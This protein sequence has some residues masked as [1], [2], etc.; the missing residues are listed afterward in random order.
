MDIQEIR[1]EIDGINKDLI[2]LMEKRLQLVEKIAI[3]KKEKGLSI[4]DPKREEAIM[5]DIEHSLT[6]TVYEP[7]IREFMEDIIHISRTLQR[8]RLKQFIYLVGMPGSGKTTVG[9]ALAAQLDI[10]F[11]DVDERIQKKA[12]QSLQHIMIKEGEPAFR[13]LENEVIKEIVTE[14]PGV[15]ATGGGTVLS[16]KTVQLMRETGIV[17]FINRD[18]EQILGDLDLEIR[19]L[20][21]ENIEYIFRLYKERYPLYESVSHIRVENATSVH[22]AVKQIEQALPRDFHA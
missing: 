9:K 19:P 21:K 14:K 22:D 11:Y 6:D 8:S 20:L 15:I 13:E 18:V 12:G 16:D 17:V 5:K 10:A 7:Y 2:S 1:K 4:F 3:Y